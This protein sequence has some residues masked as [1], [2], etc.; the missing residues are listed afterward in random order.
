MGQNRFLLIIVIALSV[1]GCAN[2][3]IPFFGKPAAESAETKDSS[4]NDREALE[5]NQFVEKGKIVNAQ[6]LKQG[7][8]IVII[9]FKAGVGVEAS[10]DMDKIALMIVKGIYDAF[11]YDKTGKH[12][13]FNILTAEDIQKPDLVVKGHITEVVKRSKFKRWI[14]LKSKKSIGIKG[15]VVDVQTGEAVVIFTDRAEPGSEKRGVRKVRASNREEHR[16]VHIVRHIE[17]ISRTPCGDDLI[18]G[19]DR[20]FICSELV[21]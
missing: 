5:P 19:P 15:K 3:N 16:P 9:P 18:F 8:N 7:K 20:N 6:K 21:V 14:M 17:V 13:H 12:A 2:I 11:D 1:T 10:D 4:F